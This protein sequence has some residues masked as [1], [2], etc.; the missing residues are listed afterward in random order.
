MRKIL[1]WLIVIL[2]MML[3]FYFSQQPVFD[4]RDLSSNIT[5]QLIEI[6]EKV[7]PLENV[8]KKQVHHL[9]RKYAHFTIYFFLGIFALLALKLTGLKHSL[10]AI[11]ALVLCM[12]YAVTDEYHQLFVEGR[13]A[14]LKDI[15]IDWAGAATGITVATL[16]GLIGKTGKP[17]SENRKTSSRYKVSE[18]S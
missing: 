3:I 10:S 17:R 7:T 18:H 1:A 11:I 15:F 14:Q 8:E 6:V 5:T 13:G 2:W 4:S 16:L 9:V 12:I